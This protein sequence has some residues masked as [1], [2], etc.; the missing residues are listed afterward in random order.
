MDNTKNNAQSTEGINVTDEEQVENTSGE[1]TE[2]V[3]EQPDLSK[4]SLTRDK[5]KKKKSNCSFS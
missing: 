3:E 5:K 4:Y 1:Q 2:I